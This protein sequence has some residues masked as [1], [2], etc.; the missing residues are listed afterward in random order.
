MIEN[1]ITIGLFVNLLAAIIIWG[2]SSVFPKARDYRGLMWVAIVMLLIVNIF[3]F[4][5][6]HKITPF[7]ALLV[8]IGVVINL[9]FKG[10]GAYLNQRAG[11]MIELPK[12]WKEFSFFECVF[13]F[14]FSRFV[15][16][17]GYPSPRLYSPDN[18]EFHGPNGEEIKLSIGPTHPSVDFEPTADE[19]IQKMRII[20]RKYGHKIKQLPNIRLGGND[21][22]V[23]FTM[24]PVGKDRSH[25]LTIKNYILVFNNMEYFVSAFLKI[26][27]PI[28]GSVQIGKEETYDDIVKTFHPIGIRHEP[29]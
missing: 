12:G 26:T 13:R 5:S 4:L 27:H 1:E 3:F 14:F 18:P 8:I 22:A 23:F 11:F 6:S 28:D 17:K 29:M 21:H 7:I 16:P 25:T 15:R 19:Q 10:P 2:F 20:C 9:R 24:I